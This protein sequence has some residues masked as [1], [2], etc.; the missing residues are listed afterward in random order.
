M[1]TAPLITPP[2]TKEG[3]PQYAAPPA[4]AGAT[5]TIPMVPQSVEMDREFIVRN[6]IAERYLA[7]R[8]P[9]RGTHDFEL[10]PPASGFIQELGLA[11][12]RSALRL[13]RRA[14]SRPGKPSRAPGGTTGPDR[15]GRAGAGSGISA[16]VFAGRSDGTPPSAR[17]VNGSPNSR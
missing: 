16:M 2:P 13:W 7:G 1:R 4:A 12:A 14:A 5:Q 6:Q 8:L 15:G 3:S 11:S 17:C 10:L 9:V